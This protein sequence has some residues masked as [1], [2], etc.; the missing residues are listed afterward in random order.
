MVQGIPQ[1]KF[2]RPQNFGFVE[3][4]IEPEAYKFGSGEVDLSQPLQLNGQWDDFLPVEEIQNIRN[5]ETS[6]CTAFGSTNQIEVYMKRKF[7]KD[8]NFSD[9]ALGIE[10]GTYPP[11]ND[12]QKVYEK[13]RKVGLADDSLLPFGDVKN[14]DEYYDK[15]KITKEVKDSERDFLDNY[16]FKHDWVASG[17][18]TTPEIMKTALQ[19][20]PLACAIFAFAFDG[21]YYVR[22]GRDGDWI[23]LTG[24]E[25]GK[26]WKGFTSYSPVVKKFAWDFGFYFVKRIHIEP[27]RTPQQI[28][29]LQKILDLI[30]K[31]LNITALRIKEKEPVIV[32]DSQPVIPPPAPPIVI[33]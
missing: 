1:M 10:A 7:T 8:Y 3:P 5:I 20:S 23:I 21:Q 32:P 18:L 12:P 30:G 27:N 31:I 28:S 33:V 17:E 13:I 26:Y 24:Y 4:V 6:N 25:D 11:G 2:N 15:N 14:V 19:Y 9:R 29:I 22:M 16:T